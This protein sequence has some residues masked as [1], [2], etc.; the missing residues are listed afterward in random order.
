MSLVVGE[1]LKRGVLDESFPQRAVVSIQK[2]GVEELRVLADRF[3]AVNPEDNSRR[4]LG[5]ELEG[6][7]FE[8]LEAAERLGFSSHFLYVAGGWVDRY[9]SSFPH[10]TTDA[11]LRFDHPIS[12]STVDL[13]GPG[14]AVR[15]ES[16]LIVG[17]HFCALSQ[18]ALGSQIFAVAL[19]PTD[20]K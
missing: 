8:F 6:H 1:E 18:G 11:K 19:N 9:E 17:R 16:G 13:E 20:E 2:F 7:A 4:G 12:L 10:P 3:R 14:Y 5:Y 15:D